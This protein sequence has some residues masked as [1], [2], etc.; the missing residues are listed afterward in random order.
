VFRL[1]RDWKWDRWIGELSFPVY[2]VHHLMMMLVKP[3]F[4]SHTQHM[5]YFGWATIGLSLAAAVLLWWLVIRPMERVR[6][7]RVLGRAVE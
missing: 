6:E 2:I 7:R 4:W 5:A 1:T 3:Y